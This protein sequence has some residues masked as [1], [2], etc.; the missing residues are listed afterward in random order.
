MFKKIKIR[1]PVVAPTNIAGG[2]E[3]DAPTGNSLHSR[4]LSTA[5]RRLMA[6]IATQPERFIREAQLLGEGCF[7]KVYGFDPGIPGLPPLAIK[8]GGSTRKSFLLNAALGV[9]L[10]TPERTRLPFELLAGDIP[11]FPAYAPTYYSF[12][13]SPELNISGLPGPNSVTVMSHAK[14]V[15]EK[16][17][18]VCE[19]R[20]TII[21]E[22]L[23]PILSAGLSCYR[24]DSK[25][26][27]ILYDENSGK[28][29]VL[30]LYQ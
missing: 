30:D 7:A 6:E 13:D 28:V 18:E 17:N 15:P 14:G 19:T 1:T 12:Y 10:A 5:S 8:V 9:A 24:P 22:A 21:L 29:T 3:F 23:N 26:A 20:N 27:N 2:I 11:T 25:G 4:S 16:T